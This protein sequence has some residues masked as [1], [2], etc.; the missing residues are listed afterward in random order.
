MQRPPFVA[1]SLRLIRSIT[2]VKA[3]HL[4][5]GVRLQKVARPLFIAAKHLLSRQVK[6]QAKAYIYSRLS[7][8]ILFNF[9]ILL[10]DE[11]MPNV[12]LDRYWKVTATLCEFSF[13]SV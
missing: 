12:Y 8:I 3:Y 11:R 4:P 6:I 2:F 1:I 13:S 5:K 7:V 10:L 9:K